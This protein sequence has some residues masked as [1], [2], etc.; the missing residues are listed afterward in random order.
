[1]LIAAEL[2]DDSRFTFDI[3]NSMDTSFQ[4]YDTRIF[5]THGDQAGG[6]SGIAGIFA[7]V[8]RLKARKQANFVFDWMILG[9][10]HQYIH[11]QGITVNNSLKGWDEFALAHA[12]PF[13]EPGQAMFIV[14]PEHKGPT[15]PIQVY[16]QNRKAEG[17]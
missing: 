12:Y 10:F 11:T 9:H 15:W 4:V 3:P 13:E 6:G 17:W 5:L 7:P 14:T 16:C 2:K 1:M 8:M